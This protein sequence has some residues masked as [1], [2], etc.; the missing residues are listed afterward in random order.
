M[1]VMDVKAP[2]GAN[3]ESDH[4]LRIARIRDRISNAKREYRD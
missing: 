3:T 2:R 4:Y 1:E